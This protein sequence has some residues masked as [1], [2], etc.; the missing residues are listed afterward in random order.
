[1]RTPSTI[2]SLLFC[3]ASLAVGAAER[4]QPVLAEPTVLDGADELHLTAADNVIADGATVTM[5]SADAWLFFDNVKPGDVIKNYASRIIIDGKP[6][7]PE[8]NGRIAIYRHGAVV[9]A[10]Q[11]GFRALTATGDGCSETF[12]AEYFYTNGAPQ[13][14][15][16]SLVRPLAH[17]NAFTHIT[18]KRGYMATLACEPDGMGYSRVFIADDQ[19]LDADLP[20]ELRGKV[21]Y[22]RVLRW[23]YP[24]KKG[25]AGSTWSSMPD[26]LKY[27]FEQAEFTNSTWYYNWGSSPTKDPAKPDE[28]N[29]N[30]EFVPEKWGAGGALGRIFE[31]ADASHLLGYNEPD[32][33]EQ[34]N[35]SVENAIK[36]W[37]VLMQT[38]RR[39]GSPATTDFTWLYSFMEQ[40]RKRNYRV[41]FVVV[42]AYW[43][44]KS[45]AA[46]YRDLKAVHDR[47]QRPVWIKEWNNGANWTNEG[48][49][50][51]QA[52]Q[53]ARQLSDITAIVNMLDTCSFVER[54]S[55]YNWVEEKRMMIDKNGKLTPAGEFYAA[56]RPAYFFNRDK[57][58][59][60]AWTVREAPSLRYDSI[61]D[62]RLHVSW[63]DPNGE[64]IDRYA[65]Y[66]DDRLLADTIR[67]L[68]VSLPVSD[69]AD[70]D[71]VVRLTVTSMPES[72][73]QKSKDSNALMVVTAPLSESPVVVGSA[74]VSESW[75]PMVTGGAN[76]ET[77]VVV[78]GTPTYRNKMPLAPMLRSVS[79]DHF[80][81]ALRAYVYQESPTFFAPDTLSYLMLPQGSF[82]WGTIE[83]E[84]QSVG[85][86]GD[87]WT[88]IDFAKTFDT[89]P[90]VIASVSA[91]NDTTAT[92]AVRNVTRSGF[93]LRLRH[94]ERVGDVSARAKVGFVAMTPGSGLVNGMKA[95][96]GRT[97]DRAVGNVLTAAYVLPYGETYK[98]AA[99]VFAQMQT[100]NDAVTSTL[101]QQKRTTATTTLFKDRE[102][103][104]SRDTVEAEQ[105]GY[106]I[107]GT[108]DTANALSRIAAQS[109]RDTW[110]ALSGVAADAAPRQR[111]VY[112]RSVQGQTQKVLVQ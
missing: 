31:T 55:I 92:V 29:Y 35:V 20:A 17:D 25:W 68:S 107:M 79:A 40:C 73:I 64:Q 76:P 52:A 101:R 103:S 102:K 38:G 58:V 16:D 54:Y 26:G 43:G 33:T 100:E 42:H 82:R 95:F 88:R 24:S 81:F 6:F 18:L 66:R 93:E 104:V 86:V 53:Y 48:W 67:G 11:R 5:A 13:Y 12:E 109:Q 14:A 85:G 97:D 15:P 71:A 98:D 41:D 47:T 65:L 77:P 60:P 4:T 96:V 28:K 36:E 45:A 89:A 74:L 111:G 21:S 32:H 99:H 3:C 2:L 23:Q 106:L 50:S 7:D 51:G 84:A 56:D 70:A 27:A 8:T 49:P 61:A 22:V 112:I 78:L 62:S 46:W 19:D 110:T 44:N 10:H 87:E 63:T 83:G 39:L 69:F 94:E 9:M 57:E 105:V 37:P 1:M 91:A 34:S 108:P 90:V 80:D 75:R 72:E 30:V 59:V